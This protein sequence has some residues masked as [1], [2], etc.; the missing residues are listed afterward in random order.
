[1]VRAQGGDP[2][3]VD[4]PGKVL[5]RAPVRVPIEP[6]AEGILAR[7]EAEA[8]GWAAARLGAGRRRKG[9][10]VDPAV[11][12][13][14]RAKVGDRL[15]PGRSIGEVHARHDEA[16]RRA[17]AEVLAALELGPDPVGPP[18]LVYGWRDAGAPSS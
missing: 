8:L 15:E 11:G 4:D 16:A 7:V 1:M 3:V 5:A 17:V 2:R 13:V 10:P 9:D 18:P 12:I 6:P 14:L